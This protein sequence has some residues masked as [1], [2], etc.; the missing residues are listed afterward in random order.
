MPGTFATSTI[1][2]SPVVATVGSPAVSVSAPS[3]LSA[4]GSSASPAAF[5]LR[6]PFASRTSQAYRVGSR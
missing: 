6:R 2:S 3:P 4:A 5:A 1:S